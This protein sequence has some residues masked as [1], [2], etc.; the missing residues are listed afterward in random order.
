MKGSTVPQAIEVK[1]LDPL[2][3]PDWD[4]A[5]LSHPDCDFFHSAAWAKVLRKTYRHQPTYLHFS[6]QGK[7]VALVPMMEVRSFLTGCRG[8][9]LPFSDFCEPLMFDTA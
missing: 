8:V 9:C 7:L 3:D 2:S 1:T 5:V 6:R 4:H